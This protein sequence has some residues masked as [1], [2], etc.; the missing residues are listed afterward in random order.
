MVTRRGWSNYKSDGI[1]AT[2]VPAATDP[3][4][5]A[6]AAVV[7]WRLLERNAGSCP[8]ANKSVVPAI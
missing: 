4:P 2:A 3:I 8:T 6:A 7:Q 1:L 5:A